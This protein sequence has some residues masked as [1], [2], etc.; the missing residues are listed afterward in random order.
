MKLRKWSPRFLRFFSLF[1]YSI[2]NVSIAFALTFTLSHAYCFFFFYY[3][4]VLFFLSL[5]LPRTFILFKI[6]KIFT[7]N[8][9][10]LII[11]HVKH[12]QVKRQAL[13]DIKEDLYNSFFFFFFSSGGMSNLIEQGSLQ[14][15]RH[16]SNN[17]TII[18]ITLYF[19]YFL[20]FS[21]KLFSTKCISKYSIKKFFILLFWR[22]NYLLYYLACVLE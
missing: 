9:F 20:F 1:I 17:L 6:L 22:Y 16:F 19:S 4:D 18:S 11:C 21:F 12:A 2:L 10:K 8:K 7:R 5:F 3:Y 15:G 14:D 13:V